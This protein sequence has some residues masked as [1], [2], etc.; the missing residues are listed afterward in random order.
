MRLKW[1]EKLEFYYKRYRQKKTWQRVVSVLGCLVVFCTTYAL[2]LPAITMEQNTICGM[3]EHQHTSDCYIMPESG[4]VHTDACYTETVTYIC[5]MEES[6]D[7]GGFFEELFGDESSTSSAI[8]YEPAEPAHSHTDACMEITTELTCGLE[9]A[10]PHSHD[11]SCFDENGE[12]I[13]ELPTELE[14]PVLICDIT[15]HIHSDGCFPS[16]EEEKTD[17]NENAENAENA[18]SELI[19]GM[20]E[21]SHIEDCYNADGELIC[22]LEEHQHT[23]SCV[24][25]AEPEKPE[26]ICGMEEHS[27][28]EDCYDENGE[29]ICAL[30]EH[31]HSESCVKEI[32]P[33]YLCGLEEHTHLENCFDETDALICTMLAH[34]HGEACETGEIPTEVHYVIILIQN[35]PGITEVE[36]KTLELED[37]EDYEGLETYWYDVGMQGRIAYEAYMELT[38]EQ[39]AILDYD[40]DFMNRLWYLEP[41]WSKV[42]LIEEIISDTPT[43]VAATSTADFITLNLYDYGSNIND[44]WNSNNKY[45]GFQWNGGAYMTSSTFSRTRVD[46]IDFGDSMIA[47][48]DYG[49]TSTGISNGYSSNRKNVVNQGGIINAKSDMYTNKPI[50]MSTGTAVLNGK[51]SANGYPVLKEIS[52]SELSW[53]F[54]DNTYA[55]KLNTANIDG[56]FQKNEVTGEYYFDC[57]DNHAQYG[58]NRFTLYNQVITP[59]FIIYPFGN[60]LPLNDITNGATATQVSKITNIGNYVQWVIN[61]LVYDRTIGSSEQQLIDMLARYRT[62]LQNAGIW[63]SWNAKQIIQ[64]YLDAQGYSGTLSDSLLQRLYNIDYDV[65]SNFFFGM[66]M[67][68]NFMQPKDGMTG[69]DTNGDGKSDYPMV[70]EFAGDD[71]VWVYIDNTLF[72]D[73]SGIHRHVGGDIDFVNG[74]VNYYDFATYVNG[75][76]SSTPATTMTFAEILT[77]YGGVAEADLGKYLKQDANG[78]YTTFLDYSSHKFDFFYMERGS[79]SSVC[80]INFNFPL[81]RQN[82]ISV[83]KELTTDDAN[84]T[85]L[86]GNPDF[87]F[88]VLKASSSGSKTEEL[89]IGAGETYTIYDA[90]NKEID[91]GI[92]DENGV[93]TLKAGQRAE[94]TG[95]KENAGNYYVRELLNPDAFEQ[96]GTISVNGSSETVTAN[97]VTIGTDT[98]KGVE[99]TVQDASNGSTLFHFNNQVTFKKTGNLEISKAL[100]TYPQQRNILQFQFEVTLDDQPLPVGTVYTVGGTNRTVTEAGIITLAPDETAKISGVLAGTAF[101]VKETAASSQG[102]SV[103]YQ[104]D[105]GTVNETSATGTIGIESTVG[106]LITNMESG[107]S[108][109]IPLVKRLSQADG[110]EHTYKFRLTQVTDQSGNT[111]VA[112][113]NEEPVCVRETEITLTEKSANGSFYLAYPQ[114]AINQLPADYYYRIEEVKSDSEPGTVFDESI[115]VVQVTVSQTDNGLSAVI[116]N[117]WK[118]GEPFNDGNTITFTNLI[119][120]YELPETGGNGTQM[121]IMAGLL[122]MAAAA[123]LLYN[124]R[125]HRREDA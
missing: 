10:V 8:E 27:H 14:E 96:Y 57:R 105:A 63:N 75:A 93:F 119:K 121:Y 72:L 5:G 54:T 51:L 71:D 2:I 111:P 89:F 78:N 39:K 64:E 70:F 79:G 122:L 52:G 81:L 15:P 68:M 113:E 3:E 90:N 92:T 6:E 21:H 28:S 56:L 73:L 104:V 123:I 97:D 25:E 33:E 32:V 38:D 37:A 118:D 99:S 108:I 43:T 91:T 84:K 85:A 19:C 26:Y 98:F 41:Y 87:R 77:E 76:V 82:T 30:E 125:W 7:D 61:D 40:E 20:E 29:L 48:Y 66:E 18:E 115:Y 11:D 16:D 53:L 62:N 45:P 31:Q 67:R 36:Q 117:V 69:N 60:F 55:D 59:N 110:N 23:E 88:Q 114:P 12:L 106:V 17:K 109:D 103:T 95:I 22:T 58:N 44:K 65:D 34:Q 100:Q 49:G 120:Q 46:N 24:K 35:L 1:I 42:T 86:L 116:T 4:H 112:N 102:Y 107:V 50:G 101:E 83:A 9:E 13:C 94:F 74:R 80:R 47:D 124:Q